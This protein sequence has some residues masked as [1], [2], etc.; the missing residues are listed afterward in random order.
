M[1]YQIKRSKRRTITLEVKSNAEI[2]IRAPFRVSDSV[3]DGLVQ[4][5]KD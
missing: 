5:R 2:V 3:I 4:K 1:Q